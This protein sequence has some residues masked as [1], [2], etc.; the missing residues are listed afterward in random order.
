MRGE[1][2]EERRNIGVLL[3]SVFYCTAG[4]FSEFLRYNQALPGGLL[5]AR[6]DKNRER[7]YRENMYIIPEPQKLESKTGSFRLRYNHAVCL[8]DSCA[9]EN[10]LHARL[11]Q[12]E[13]SESAGM[14]LPIVRG[15]SQK[16]GIRLAVCKGGEPESYTLAVGEDGVRILGADARGLLWGIQTLRQ[17]IRQEGAQLPCVVIED[18]PQMKNRGFYHDATRSR[19]PKMSWLKRLA[20]TLSFYKMNQ[21]QLYIEHTYLFE[22]LSEMWRDDTPL[23]AEEIMELDAYCSAIGIE[24]VPSLS[25]FG[26]LHKLL[27]TK[28]YQHLCEMEDPRKEPFRFHDRMAHHTINVTMEESAE[29]IERMIAEFMPLFRSKYFNICADETF[30]LGKGAAKAAADEIG[31]ENLYIGFVKRLGEFVLAKGRIPMFWGDVICGFPEFIDKLPKEM[32]CLNWGYA[33]N[34]TED[35]AKAL[36]EAGAVQYVCPGVGGWNQFTTLLH[37]SYQNI[38]RMCSYGVKYGAI[39]MLNTDWGD[40]GHI[41]HPSF[42]IPGMIY[43]AEFSWNRKEVS[44]EEMNRR[45]SRV[46]Y[47]DSSERLLSVVARLSDVSVFGWWNAVNYQETAATRDT[48]PA[49]FALDSEE[50]L[51]RAKEKNGELPALERQLT[52]CLKT[53]DTKKKGEIGA[54]LIAADGM[55]LFNEIGCIVSGEKRE[56]KELL[57]LAAELEAWYDDFKKLWRSVSRESELYQITR[58]VC[59]YAD[60][61]RTMAGLEK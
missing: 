31:V 45:I 29:L 43:G 35:S 18:A 5:C 7:R 6:K 21:L 30:D 8:E 42:S 19:V 54:Y 40:Y 11:L 41:N 2:E 37:S 39:G 23:T 13:L 36:A 26:H 34:Q 25:C 24:L 51:A 59:W 14:R 32:I 49:K 20:D 3:Y 33:W 22:G 57:A 27:R 17:M 61:L 16:G 1:T 53:M 52:D 47:M 60:T 46:E 4:N 44:F 28:Q 48:D 56:R 15:S 38:T 58:V 12:G 55:R 10:F 9:A 50:K